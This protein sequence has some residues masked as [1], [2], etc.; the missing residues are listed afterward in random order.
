MSLG[1]F[2]FGNWRIQDSILCLCDSW[3]R[4]LYSSAS[5]PSYTVNPLID[6]LCSEENASDLFVSASVPVH[7]Q[8]GKWKLFYIFIFQAGNW[9]RSSLGG[10]KKECY[11]EV[12]K[13]HKPHPCHTAATFVAQG[14]IY[15]CAHCWRHLQ[16]LEKHGVFPLSPSSFLFWASHL[17]NKK[18]LGKEVWEM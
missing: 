5:I 9:S 4:A 10:R 7:D 16:I 2:L 11:S 6:D 13:L 3:S 18:P 17:L 15:C 14:A 8:S 12:R 1:T